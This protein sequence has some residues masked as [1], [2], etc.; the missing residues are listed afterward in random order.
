VSAEVP[1]ETRAVERNNPDGTGTMDW[2]PIEQTVDEELAEAGDEVTKKMR[3]MQR[4]MINSL[5]LSK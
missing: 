5:D 2:K 3:E 1:D 4:E